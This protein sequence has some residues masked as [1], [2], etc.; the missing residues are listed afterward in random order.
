[1]GLF[2]RAR[3]DLEKVVHEDKL[4]VKT[5]TVEDATAQEEIS[6]LKKEIQNAAVMLE[7][8]SQELEKQRAS[9]MR[10][11]KNQKLC[12]KIWNQ[13]ERISSQ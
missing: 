3:K 7:T 5:L 13:Q 1:M 6:N 2:G 10:L 11:P 12:K 8:Y 4:D 9:L